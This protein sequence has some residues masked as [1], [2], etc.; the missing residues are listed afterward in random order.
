MPPPALPASSS[1]ITRAVG[2][3]QE[4][5]GLEGTRKLRKLHKMSLLLVAVLDYK[6][7]V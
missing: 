7:V 6:D 4:R 2:T 1:C 3:G 5:L